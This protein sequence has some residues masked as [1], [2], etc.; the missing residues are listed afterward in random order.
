MHIFRTRSN[1]W[2]EHRTVFWGEK[3]FHLSLRLLFDNIF[4]SKCTSN[5]YVLMRKFRLPTMQIQ[6]QPFVPFL[7]RRCGISRVSQQ[8][9]EKFEL[10]HIHECLPYM[11]MVLHVHGKRA[12]FIKIRTGKRGIDVLSTVK[13]NS[14]I[15]LNDPK[16]QF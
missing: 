8:G 10:P 9:V 2:S 12:I 15:L 3:L 11:F 7:I 1:S 14:I 5:V 13:I 4:Y 16:H 6:S